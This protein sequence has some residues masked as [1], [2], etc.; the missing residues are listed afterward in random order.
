MDHLQVI[1]SVGYA[2]TFPRHKIRTALYP[3]TQLYAHPPGEVAIRIRCMLATL[4]HADYV[5][6]SWVGPISAA[7]A[8]QTAGKGYA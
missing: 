7:R 2:Q 3:I 4:D 8:R 1:R 6:E 5:C